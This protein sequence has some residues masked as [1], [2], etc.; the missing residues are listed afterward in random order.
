MIDGEQYV[1]PPSRCA[2]LANI[3]GAQNATHGSRLVKLRALWAMVPPGQLV[4]DH[5][6]SVKQELEDIDNADQQATAE[7]FRGLQDEQER[8]V[9]VRVLWASPA[10]G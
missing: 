4:S 3:R 9:E 8:V 1:N 5:V 6:E 2:V 7:L 10:S